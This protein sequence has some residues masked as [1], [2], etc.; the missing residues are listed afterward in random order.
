M[1]APTVSDSFFAGMIT[2]TVVF[3][4]GWRFGRGRIRHGEGSRGLRCWHVMKVRGFR[5]FSALDRALASRPELMG[6]PERLRDG[7]VEVATTSVIQEHPLITPGAKGRTMK[8]E[9]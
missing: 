4:F 8:R 7:P 9:S 2:A 3:V 6:H 1:T 5:W